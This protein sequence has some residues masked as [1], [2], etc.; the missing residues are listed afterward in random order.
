[1]SEAAF[2][3]ELDEPTRNRIFR[4]VAAGTH[5]ATAEEVIETLVTQGLISLMGSAGFRDLLLPV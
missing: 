3:I 1:V 4:L 2:Q 5:G